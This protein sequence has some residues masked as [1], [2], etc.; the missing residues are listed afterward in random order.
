MILYASVGVG[1]AGACM[2]GEGGG[3]VAGRQSS[4]PTADCRTSRSGPI[5]PTAPRLTSVESEKK[6]IMSI[7]KWFWK[8]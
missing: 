2:G 7:K 4:L 1:H 3:G 8:K 5:V 6:G